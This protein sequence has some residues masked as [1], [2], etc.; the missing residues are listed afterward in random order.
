MK[1][2]DGIRKYVPLWEDWEIDRVIGVGAF[3]KVY[4][5]KKNLNTST[6][7]SAVKY[8]TIPNREQ[9]E[10]AMLSSVSYTH[11]TLPTKA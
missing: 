6:A 11:L 9:Y 8:I 5:I 1:Y 7:Y 4:R 2:S 10:E 3:G